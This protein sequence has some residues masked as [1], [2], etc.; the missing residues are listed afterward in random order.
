MTDFDLLSESLR[1]YTKLV[2]LKLLC[3]SVHGRAFL[4]RSTYNNDADVEN[5][6]NDDDDDD[7]DDDDLCSTE[8]AFCRC[9]SRKK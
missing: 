3:L 2:F 4:V 7:N 5:A 9:L 1:N 8:I 6:D